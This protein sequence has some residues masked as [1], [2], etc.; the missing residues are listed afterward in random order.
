MTMTI[1][2]MK[3]LNGECCQ[4]NCSEKATHYVY[5]PGETKKMM[6]DLHTAKA[7]VIGKHMGFHIHTEV[8]TGGG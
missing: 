6:C 8:I 7:K 5:W 3:E 1:R 2:E 4:D